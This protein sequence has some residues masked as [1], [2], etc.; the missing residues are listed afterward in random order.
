LFHGKTLFSCA[1]PFPGGALGNDSFQKM[2]PF[3]T[4]FDLVPVNEE[5]TGD[6]D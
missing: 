5:K 4:F 6:K 1:T 2:G 3:E